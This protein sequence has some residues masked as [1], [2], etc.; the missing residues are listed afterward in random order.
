MK[1]KEKTKIQAK[2]ENYS[3]VYEF[4]A[5]VFPLTGKARAPWAGEESHGQSR[6]SNTGP[7]KSGAQ[8]PC[9][10]SLSHGQSGHGQNFVQNLWYLGLSNTSTYNLVLAS[11]ARR[12]MLLLDCFLISV[13]YRFP[14]ELFRC[15]IVVKHLDNNTDQ[16]NNGSVAASNHFSAIL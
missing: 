11:A 2:D 15:L 16:A 13:Q 9:K 4:P 8:Q 1:L 5:L 3:K 14:V 12:I 7:Q 6:Q 10:A